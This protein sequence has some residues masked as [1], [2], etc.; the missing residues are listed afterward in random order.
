M[1]LFLVAF[2]NINLNV[3]YSIPYTK[4]KAIFISM[5]LL[6]FL[7][8]QLAEGCKKIIY[9]FDNPYKQRLLNKQG[10]ENLNKKGNI[11]FK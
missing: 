4:H 6:L 3:V 10:Q 11:I 7:I 8:S 9:F 2:T 5:L 1:T